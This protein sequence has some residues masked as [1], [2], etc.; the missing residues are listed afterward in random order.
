[1]SE[2]AKLIDIMARLR[3]PDGCPWDQEQTLESLQK[4]LIEET[5]EV[6]DAIDSGDPAHHCDELGDLLLQVVFQAQIRSESGAFTFED[7]ARSINDKMIRRHP[8]V[9]GDVS[10]KDSDEVLRN[11][12]EIKAQEKGSVDASASVLDGVPKALP[13]LM[14]ADKIQRKAARVGFDWGDVAPVLDK[15]DEELGELRAAIASGDK[16]AVQEEMGDLLFAAVNVSRFLSH[17]AEALLRV[18]TAKFI[19]RFQ[20]LETLALGRELELTNMSLDELDV[21]WDEVKRS[22]A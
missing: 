11:W 15:V 19:D 18:A 21:L 10:V 6:I 22:G 17:D 9:F 12:E 7:V 20:K 2:V 16:A 4:Y 8:H 13:A 3:A 14:Y 1:M 5:Y